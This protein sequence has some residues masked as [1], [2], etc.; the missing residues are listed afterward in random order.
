MRA[1]WKKELYQYATSMIGAVFLA[2]Y[3]A[4]V[5]YYFTV[6]NLLAANGDVSALFHSI[7]SVLMVF[8]PMLTMR[9]FAEEKKLRTEQLIFTSPVSVS[10]IVMGKFLAAFC[11]FL[12]GSIPVILAIA[13]LGYYGVF[14][15]LETAGN[16]CGLCLAGAAFL[17]IGLFSSSV[18]ENQLVAAIM[19][20]VIMLGLWMLDFLKYY[21][22]NRW[23]IAMIEYLSFRAHFE[24]LSAGIFSFSS[25]AYFT[26]LTF[27]MLGWTQLIL[28][29]RRW[30]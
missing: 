3:A 18:T 8:I 25:I 7:F 22:Q 30:K 24:E 13:I 11:I 20:Y 6:G 21:I 12:V 23:L 15:C 17:S 1:V 4:M 16:L 29:S 2:S 10:Q 5:G 14:Q 19:S 26:T 28:E 27:L 9:L